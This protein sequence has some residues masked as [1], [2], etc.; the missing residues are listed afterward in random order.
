LK[1]IIDEGVPRKIVSH[2]RG[3]GH[4]VQPFPN[5][6]KGLTNGRLL[7]AMSSKGY[8]CL[9]T[10]DKNLM[11]QQNLASV[12]I[13]VVVL[14]TQDLATRIALVASIGDT[15]SRAQPGEASFVTAPND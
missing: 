14:P 13:A 8:D 4:D 2:L 5:A 3:E 15:L 10:C 11:H 7:A 6:W 9:L 1:T 12:H